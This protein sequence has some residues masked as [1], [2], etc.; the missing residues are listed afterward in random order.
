MENLLV[1]ANLVGLRL[2]APILAPMLALTAGA[3]FLL[4]RDALRPLVIVGRSRP[5]S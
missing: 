4:A 3:T 5:A 1:E 2:L